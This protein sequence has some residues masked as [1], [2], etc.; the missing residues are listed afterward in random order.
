MDPE[1]SEML[2]VW[3]ERGP[4]LI[5]AVLEE[6][7]RLLDL[8]ALHRDDLSTQLFEAQNEITMLRGTAREK[9][10]DH[11]NEKSQMST[12]VKQLKASI[13][14]L[15][16]E[17]KEVKE[18]N[19]VTKK[20]L[21]Q[22]TKERDKAL[23]FIDEREKSAENM[24]EALQKSL[25]S[26]AKAKSTARDSI[27]NLQ[28]ENIQYTQLVLNHRMRAEKESRRANIAERQVLELQDKLEKILSEK[29]TTSEDKLRT[30]TGRVI[31]NSAH[32]GSKRISTSA[33][34]SEVMGPTVEDVPSEVTQNEDILHD[35]S[36]TK[37]PGRRRSEEKRKTAE[38]ETV[39][40]KE[41][42]PE[43][44]HSQFRPEPAKH[45]EP[46]KTHKTRKRKTRPLP[47]LPIAE[48]LLLQYEEKPPQSKFNLSHST[49][50]NYERP[51]RKRPKVSYVY[52]IS[53]DSDVQTRDKFC[54]PVCK[55]QK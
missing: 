46:Y 10:K 18:E 26:E 21:E 25:H 34:T 36:T 16:T 42:D 4:T 43:E 28:Q 7:K 24:L 37:Q 30:S 50:L 2:R 47:P 52:P 20:K 53:G 3:G 5:S 19:E 32:S 44:R 6:R 29:S 12:T 11:L 13:S 45:S 51:R 17:M 8:A 54:A 31:P 15:T 40:R 14:S 9:E 39:E 55:A 27:R 49:P 48:N 23:Y 41:D 22:V 1:L 35:R 33:S 38:P